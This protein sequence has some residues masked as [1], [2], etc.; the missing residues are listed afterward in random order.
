MSPTA[1]A[2]T[3]V[4]KLLDLNRVSLFE[5]V[6]QFRAV[7]GGGTP[8]ST[9]LTL[10]SV[11]T[12][13]VATASTVDQAAL[14]AWLVDRVQ[15][16][17]DALDQLLTAIVEGSYLF[18]LLEQSLHCGASL[19]RI[20]IDFRGLVVP[21]FERRLCCLLANQIRASVGS[22]A[23]S[24]GSPQD[25]FVEA[26]L[27]SRLGLHNAV[28]GES[29]AAAIA[30]RDMTTMSPAT[31]SPSG[32]RSL[33]AP[34]TVLLE[35]PP[36][37]L[38][39]NGIIVALNELRAC[40]AF[41]PVDT[42]VLLFSSAMHEAAHVLRAAASTLAD[43]DSKRATL[44][45]MARVAATE[46]APFVAATLATLLGVSAHDVH[47]PLAVAFAGMYTDASMATVDVGVPGDDASTPP[48][49]AALRTNAVV[50]FAGRSIK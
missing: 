44:E 47:A 4:S 17:V 29:V 40:T 21:R 50:R 48:T 36:L 5:V 16:L 31:A 39:A 3:L 19:G 32:T 46:L 27:L 24:F 10:T 38:F 26:S 37:A 23:D 12:A 49:D 41:A 34:P 9:G 1:S 6:T 25:W 20:G 22:F 33:L 15:L 11:T 35:Y 14:D 7:F 2:Y 30:D 13:A 43:K 18:S 42:S 45:R 28:H 8:N